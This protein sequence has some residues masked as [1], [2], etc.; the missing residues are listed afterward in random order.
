[1]CS[2]SI[3]GRHDD[4][5]TPQDVTRILAANSRRILI[6]YEPGDDFY[7]FEVRTMHVSLSPSPAAGQDVRLGFRDV[8]ALLDFLGRAARRLVEEEVRIQEENIARTRR[9][10]G[11]D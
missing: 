3:P 10:L 8:P 11:E 5:P 1:M 6:T 9:A 4:A 7:A 2:S